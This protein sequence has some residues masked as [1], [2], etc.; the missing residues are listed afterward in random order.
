MTISGYPA[1]LAYI[2][3][4]SDPARQP[5]TSNAEAARNVSRMQALLA[6]AGDPQRAMGCVIVAGTKGKGSTCALLERMLQ[7]GSYRTGLWS[8][9]HL[10]SYRERIQVN[11]A[12]ITPEALVATLRTLQPLLDSFDP[13]PYGR[14]SSFDVG[15]LCAMHYFAQVGVELAVLE[16]GVG[17][18]YDCVNA[19]TPLVSVIS[20][21]SYDHMKIL[22]DTLYEIA[23]N[24]AGIIK[25][26]VSAVTVPQLPAAAAALR[27]EARD[28]GTALWVAHP[29]GL[30][31]G[32]GSFHTP[33]PVEPQPTLLRGPFQREN[34]RLALGAALVL[35]EQGVNLPDTALAEGVAE[36][37]WPGRLELVGSEPLLV[38]DGA[39]NGDSAHKLAIALRAEF[40]YEKLVLVLGTSRDKDIEGIC[41]GLVPHADHLVLTRSAHHRAL[42]D[43]DAL[44][45]AA[46][47]HLR[48]KLHMTQSIE[49][50]LQQARHLAQRHDLVCITGSLF[51]VGAVRSLLGL[52]EGDA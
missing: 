2:D 27:H 41:A 24:K 8:S 52:A 37:H 23:W 14:P 46:R 13:Q 47:P 31:A 51:V 36:A 39:H 21:I 9:P 7:A 32:L 25:A 35:R 12:L 22:G 44:A 40:A 6:A 17:G 34:A 49:E 18:R 16:V 30:T 29:W 3:G 43:L 38:L 50:A 33:Y 26:G 48:G 11:R 28:V 4:F 5:A 20:S 15:F 1:A 19:I 42:A 45:T 10:N